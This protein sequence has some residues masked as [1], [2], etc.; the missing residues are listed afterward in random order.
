MG[1]RLEAI[2]GA[3][4]GTVERVEDEL[5]DRRGVQEIAI[6]RR[7]AGSHALAELDQHDESALVLAASGVCDSRARADLET[8]TG[9][10]GERRMLACVPDVCLSMVHDRGIELAP[11]RRS[12]RLEALKS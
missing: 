9:F 3:I 2:V 5:R 12:L 1:T 6:E 7:R 8:Q 10:V 4:R 11:I